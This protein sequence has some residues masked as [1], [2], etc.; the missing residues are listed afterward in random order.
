MSGQAQQEERE[1]EA[2]R[3]KLVGR[4]AVAMAVGD[5]D[6]LRKEG[7]V[8][9]AVQTLFSALA[10]NPSA[11]ALHTSLGRLL[12]ERAEGA[13]AGAGALDDALRVM[14]RPVG[15]LP[16][17]APGVPP[18]DAA[19][20]LLHLK[21]A[22]DLHV[23]RSSA[24]NVSNVGRGAGAEEGR[25]GGASLR[26]A[27]VREESDAAWRE[28]TTWQ[29]RLLMMSQGPPDALPQVRV[30]R[31]GCSVGGT[32]HVMSCASVVY[33]CIYIHID[34]Y[35]YIYGYIETITH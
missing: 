5:A 7:N 4:Q 10:H 17:P 32:L 14:V 19:R 35:R 24:S 11:I 33:T 25:G 15:P 31:L 12:L 13:V 23:Q 34:T 1:R 18:A 8:S 28:T 29:Q 27:A 2:A 3:A 26:E 16:P 9:E 6:M 20:A 21:T 30:Q 22:R